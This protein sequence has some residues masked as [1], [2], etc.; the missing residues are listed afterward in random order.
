MDSGG[1]NWTVL[2]SPVVAFGG[3]ILA[4]TFLMKIIKMGKIFDYSYYRCGTG[5]LMIILT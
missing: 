4:L 3:E 1:S 2:V 5:V